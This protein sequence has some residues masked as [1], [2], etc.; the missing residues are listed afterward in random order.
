M[1]INRSFCAL[2]SKWGQ[3]T[4]VSIAFGLI[5]AALTMLALVGATQ[6][7]SAPVIQGA[8]NGATLFKEKCTSCHTIGGGTLLGPDLIDVTTRRDPD[9]IKRFIA[10][11]PKMFA[12]D[13]TAQALL[14]EY[15]NFAMPNLGLAPDQVNDLVD[16]LSNPGAAPAPQNVPG[17][18]GVGDTIAG[19]RLFT[20]TIALTNGGTACIACHTVSGSGSLGGGSLGPNLTHVIRRLG[21]P[22]IAAA[23]QNIVFPT[24]QGPYQN[25]PLAPQEVA[26]LIAFLK[27]ADLTQGPILAINPG[28]LTQNTF[29]VFGIALVGAVILFGL[30]LLLWSRSKRRA[31]NHLPERNPLLNKRRLS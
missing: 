10:D 11:P 27:S 18:V 9:W 25:R 1:Q 8:A 30:L 7:K 15:K 16:Y 12:S 5:L 29:L 2:K 21:E 22:G 6:A 14:Q 31:A 23:L 28:A 19:E 17:A 4:R 24:M 13:P 26:D 3:A 20:G